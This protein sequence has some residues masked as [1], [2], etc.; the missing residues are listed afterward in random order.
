MKNLK[1][2]PNLDVNLYITDSQEIAYILRHNPDLVLIEKIR[3][4]YGYD[5]FGIVQM[6][7]V[8]LVMSK[9][10]IVF[11]SLCFY[12]ATQELLNQCKDRVCFLNNSLLAPV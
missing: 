5:Y 10:G 9:F 1:N 4:I 3:L 7:T 11:S 8:Y 12:K 2:L 6:N